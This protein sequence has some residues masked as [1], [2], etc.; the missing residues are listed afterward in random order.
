[1]N[2]KKLKLE[3][4]ISKER[5][6]EVSLTGNIKR[7]GTGTDNIKGMEMGTGSDK[8][9]GTGTGT[10]TDTINRTGTGTDSAKKRKF[11]QH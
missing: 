10:G 6:R 11:A 5:E 7:M 1:M 3:R 2:N 4:Y 8:L 9:K